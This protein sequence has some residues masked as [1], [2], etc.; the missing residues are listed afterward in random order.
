MSTRKHATIRLGLGK[1]RVE[2]D[3]Q[4]LPGV[5]GL[6]LDAST[7]EDVPRLTV[8]LAMDEVEVDGEMTVQ[9]P[10]RTAAALAALGWTPPEGSE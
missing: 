5:T 10:D 6:R 3:G 2:I 4:R 9:I 8:H 1:G 7:D